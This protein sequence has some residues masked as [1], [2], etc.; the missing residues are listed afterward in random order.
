MSDFFV[1][2]IEA[3]AFGFAPKNWAMCN[4]QILPIAQY[5]ALFSLLG[6]S[7]GGNGTSNFALPDL[8]GRL[9]MGQG[10]GPGLTARNLGEAFGEE[11]HT[12]LIS[13]TP[14]HNHFVNAISNPTVANVPTPGP[15]VY[16]S[17]TSFSGP[18]GAET[19][20]Y[21]ADSAPGNTMNGGALSVVGGQPH[22]NQMPT[23][24]MNY[25]ICLFGIFPSRN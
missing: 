21:V 19:D 13:E 24:V 14:S 22:N 6:T 11:N 15:S 18:L 4:G 5:Q 8:R 1:G 7:F 3:F 9:P 2:E 10:Q 23:L 20:L 25:C 17:T 16:L 12:L